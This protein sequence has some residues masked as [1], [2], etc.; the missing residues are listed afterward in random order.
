MVRYVRMAKDDG[1]LRARLEELAAHARPGFKAI[2]LIPYGLRIAQIC[3]TIEPYQYDCESHDS[4][5]T[6]NASMPNE[7]RSRNHS[8]PCSF[9]WFLALDGKSLAR[10]QTTPQS[11]Q[12]EL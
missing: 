2:S 8:L 10:D 11:E 9:R 6:T 4:K 12:V 1:P 5:H 7:G 3:D